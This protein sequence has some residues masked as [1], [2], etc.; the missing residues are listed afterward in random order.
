MADRIIEQR[1]RTINGITAS[2]N[3]LFLN[4]KVASCL[5]QSCRMR[6][7]WEISQ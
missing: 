7:H 1:T 4:M 6:S 2:V 3:F 5:E